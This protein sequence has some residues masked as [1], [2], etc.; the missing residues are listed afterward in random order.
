M[1]ICYLLNNK[2][3]ERSIALRLGKINYWMVT[4]SSFNDLFLVS[5]R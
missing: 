2:I 1:L 5:H 3:A 4:M